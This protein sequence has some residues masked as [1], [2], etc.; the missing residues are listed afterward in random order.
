M[1]LAPVESQKDGF[2][3]EDAYKRSLSS[4]LKG[5]GIEVDSSEH[6]AHIIAG[7]HGYGCRS[8]TPPRSA[9]HSGLS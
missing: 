6:V 4:A 8:E 7:E 1:R 3:S 2:M 5:L 9:T